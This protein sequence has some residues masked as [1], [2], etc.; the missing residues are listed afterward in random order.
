MALRSAVVK[1]AVHQQG[2]GRFPKLMA[3]SFIS[4]SIEWLSLD[5]RLSELTASLFVRNPFGI[6]NTFH[7][8]VI[9][10][11]SRTRK[12]ETAA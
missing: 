2:E 12:E 7:H 9:E 11:D 1:E 5:E 4:K 8:Y 6:P 3:Q 10:D